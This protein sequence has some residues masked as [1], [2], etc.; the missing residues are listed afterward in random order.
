MRAVALV[1]AP[2]GA[3]KRVRVVA[4]WA[5]VTQTG[6]GTG[7]FCGAPCGA[8]KRVRGVPNLDL[9]THAG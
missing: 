4:T 7:A 1:G 3:T 5:W 6:G 9:E 8:T 2:Y